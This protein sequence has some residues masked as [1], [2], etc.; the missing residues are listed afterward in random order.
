MAL[1]GQLNTL[2]E[3]TAML[4]QFVKEQRLARDLTQEYLAAKLGV[5][6]PTYRKIENG[7]R[8]LALS[9]AERLAEELGMTLTDLHQR[10]APERNVT[11]REPARKRSGRQFR[12]RRRSPAKFQQVLLYVLTQVGFRPNV[13]EAVL[14]KLLYFI[15]FDYY[16]K[17]EEN[18]TGV[19]YVRSSS[20]P[21]VLA[22]GDV[23]KQMQK[24]KYLEPI[25]SRHYM[26]LQKKYLPLVLPDLS[27]LSARE[28]KHIDEVLACLGHMNARELEAYSRNDLPWQATKSD[29]AIS[30]ETVFYRD[31]KYSKRSYD[32][33]L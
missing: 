8:E 26:R 2:R 7:G 28:V 5:S 12:V 25:K 11:V 3:T 19:T 13:G 16:E 20:G 9:E 17:F 29:K 4:G 22:L 27:V 23:L 1:R 24:R 10:R 21:T 18:L 14:H 32:D 33:E 30:Y 6:R 15:D 31:S